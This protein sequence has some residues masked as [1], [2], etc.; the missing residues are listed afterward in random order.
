[1]SVAA[2]LAGLTPTGYVAK[3]AVDVATARVK[4]VP[5]GV[6]DAIAELLAARYQVQKFSG[7]VNQAVAKWHSTDELPAQLLAAVGLVGRVL[8]RLEEAA[9]AVRTSQQDAGRRR[10]LAPRKAKTVAGRGRGR[11]ACR[12]AGQRRVGGAGVIGRVYRG[13]NV[14]GLLRYLYGPGRHNEHESPHLV[15]AWDLTSAQELATLEPEVLAGHGAHAVRDFRPMTASMELATA[16]RPASVT[17]RMV[18]HCPLRVAPGHRSLTDAE[19]AQVARDVMHRTGIAPQGDPG[20]CRWIAVR[21]DEE[22]IH[23]VAVLARQDGSAARVP[24]D[25]RRVREACLAA[26]KRYGLT[27]TAPVD[28]TAATHTSRAE[29]EKAS[30][31]AARSGGGVG[32]VPARDWLREQ[33]QHAA[34]GARDPREF[35][36][37]LRVAGVIVRERRAPDGSLSGYAVGRR[38]PVTEPVLYGGGKLAPD[39]TLPKLQ[40]RWAAAGGSGVLG[41]GPSA[42]EQDRAQ[43]WKQAT[44]AAAHAAEQV[45]EHAGRSDVAG[46]AGAGDAAAAAAEVLTAA[47]RLI[48]G[49]GGGPLTQA[50]RDYDRAAREASGRRLEPTLAG[51]ML[52]TAALQLA[53]SSEAG[54]NEAAQIALL[55]AQIGSL[56]L[57]VSRLREAQGRAA[58]AAAA[59]RAAG[60]V[61]DSADR[62]LGEVRT[63]VAEQERRKASARRLTVRSSTPTKRPHGPTQGPGRSR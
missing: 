54:R 36:D 11:C 50:A 52:R 51:A 23:I 46:M 5:T 63:L 1:V 58:Q 25:Y 27:V 14:G 18:W 56:S 35:L 40:A 30:R 26:E 45:R 22:S 60:R 59:R 12:G 7:L 29:V 28:R 42:L 47:S 33:V 49:D 39:L 13:G 62:W 9:A 2:A 19:W 31:S 20:G 43:L 4:P 8:P 17:D 38:E 3:V 32:A 10:V 16:L 15:A 41:G 55:V 48:E 34:A 44:E 53:R 57:S 37:R 21:H 61:A 24:N 6:T